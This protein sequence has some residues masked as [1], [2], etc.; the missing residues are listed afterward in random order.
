[1]AQGVLPFQYEEEREESG[2]T[3]QAGMGIYLDMAYKVGLEGF[4]SKL[5]RHPTSPISTLPIPMVIFITYSPGVRLLLS[6]LKMV[7]DPI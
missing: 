2:L 5:P 7:S 3:A 1:M 4:I 6:F